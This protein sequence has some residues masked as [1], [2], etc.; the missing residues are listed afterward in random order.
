MPD[1]FFLVNTFSSKPFEGSS[2]GVCILEKPRELDWM[3]STSRALNLTDAAF[4]V[5]KSPNRFDLR[6]ITGSMEVEL[7]ISATLAA[8]HALFTNRFADPG[9]SIAFFTHAG[10]VSATTDGSQIEVN[11]PGLPIEE[12]ECPE[13]ILQAVD[14]SPKF[15][16]RR[17]ED[18]VVQ[19]SSESALK[20][21]QPDFKLLNG[22]GV[23]G[24]IVTSVAASGRE[25][26]FAIRTFQLHPRY[27]LE[28]PVASWA[29]A[30]L[31]PFWMGRLGKAKMLGFRHA[32]RSSVVSLEVDGDRVK[33][34]G[35]AIAILQGELKV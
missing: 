6:C 21:V 30:A 11:F 28:A 1:H 32:P 5:A 20:K 23:H 16:G 25:Y 10:P 4:L 26:D 9:R 34:F 27:S 12:I 33:V 14:P 15:V 18:F 19:V 35:E 29:Y 24:L 2:A 7:G 17:G 31:T 13:E 3:V 8:A 22:L